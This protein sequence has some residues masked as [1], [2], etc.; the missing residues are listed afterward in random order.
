MVVPVSVDLQLRRLNSHLSDLKRIENADNNEEQSIVV[1][2]ICNTCMLLLDKSMNKLWEA[3]VGKSSG[4]PNIYFP[5]CSSREKLIARF[6]QYQMPQIP[7]S[8]TEIFHLIDSVQEYNGSSW[9]S[10]LHKI[11]S[12]RHERYPDVGRV[13]RL[14]VGIGFDQ[15]LY[16]ESLTYDGNGN[17]SFKGHGINRSNGLIEPAK[18][19][20]I[21]EVG[22]ILKE[23]DQ[24]PF[25]FCS[26]SI[27]KVKK[28]ISSLYM[29][30]G[31][32]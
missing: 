19:E 25:Q 27:G 15:D 31:K 29:M 28:I 8:D 30:I 22:T 2:E 21:N 4:K 9:L 23:V 11:S 14:G 16:I 24:D 17:L 12:M 10:S 7:L 1:A 32:L 20:V 5:V 6:K 18:I 26:E 13:N 3:K